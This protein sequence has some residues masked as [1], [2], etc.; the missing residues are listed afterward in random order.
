MAASDYT[1]TG[2]SVMCPIG[3]L[4][5]SIGYSTTTLLLGSLRNV[6]PGDVFVGMSAMI[7][8]EIVKVTVVDVPFITVERGCADTIPAVH[9]SGSP[10]WFFSSS[11]GTDNKIYMATDTKAVKILPYTVLGA[12]I[13][14]E[15]SPPTDITFNWRQYRPY[16]PGRVMVE[17]SAWYNGYKTMALGDD[18]L[19]W[20]WA[21]RDRVQQADQLVGHGAASVGPEPGTTYTV[22]VRSVD[23]TLLRTVNGITGTTWTY[24]RAMVEADGHTIPEA[25]VDLWSVRD[26]LRSLQAYRTRVWLEG[27]NLTSFNYGAL[28]W[29][30]TQINCGPDGTGGLMNAGTLTWD[31][32]DVEWQGTEESWANTP[33]SPMIFESPTHDLGAVGEHKF[34]T[35][36]VAQGNVLAQISTSSDGINYT[37]WITPPPEYIVCRYVRSRF[38][39]SGVDPTLASARLGYFRRS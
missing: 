17:G 19:V 20:T 32:M 34:N 24:T 9:Q 16:P 12:N 5:S 10:V 33:T 14:V 35:N 29:P 23:G 11:M 1:I 15:S 27:G 36:A 3:T 18:D 25:Y 21:H 2:S 39:V 31:D 37:A 22:E 7:D 6:R 13:P 30:G 26:G 8:D 4:A 28:G 38:T